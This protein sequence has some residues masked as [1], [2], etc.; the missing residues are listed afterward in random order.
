MSQIATSST[1][2]ARRGPTRTALAVV[3]ALAL[4]LV[5]SGTPSPVSALPRVVSVSVSAQTGTLNV[6]TGGS[7]TYLVTVTN[8]TNSSLTAG[9]APSGSPPARRRRS[10]RSARGPRTVRERPAHR[11]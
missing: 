7:V 8:G 9:L 4:A 11:R 3:V 2:R 1:H 10:R 6:G 5:V